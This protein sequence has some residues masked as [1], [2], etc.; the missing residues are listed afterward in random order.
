M[1]QLKTH[2]IPNT[3]PVNDRLLGIDQ[4]CKVESGEDTRAIIGSL[5]EEGDAFSP[6]REDPKKNTHVMLCLYTA[7]CYEI[8]I[9]DAYAN[10]TEGLNS[11]MSKMMWDNLVDWATACD[12][13]N[14]TRSIPFEIAPRGV[15][16][17]VDSGVNGIESEE[18]KIFCEEHG[19]LQYLQSTI[20]LV[21]ECFPSI[22]CLFLEKEEDP[23]SDEEWITIDITVKG[24]IEGILDNYDNYI[25]MFV[26]EIPWPEREKI[27]LIYNIL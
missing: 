24:D 13:D 12:S 21:E 14:Q 2:T 1:E 20:D 18:V 27:I 10:V 15:F 11:E 4:F 7:P 16:S 23:E 22:Q 8:H 3:I 19:L 6:F 5:R 17:T 26:S 9:A 25:T